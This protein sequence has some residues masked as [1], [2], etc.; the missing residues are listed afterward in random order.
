MARPSRSILMN[1]NENTD[2]E[3][4]AQTEPTLAQLTMHEIPCPKCDKT[5]KSIPAVRMHTIRA[6]G[7]GWDTSGNFGRGSKKR[8]TESDRLAY[9]REYQKKLRER[10]KLEGKNSRGYPLRKYRWTPEQTAKFRRTMRK[11][12]IQKAAKPQRFQIVYPDPRDKD[13]DLQKVAQQVTK[14]VMRFCPYCGESI[15]KHI[16]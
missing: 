14:A 8:R 16:R 12:A 9:K 13:I 1:T 5:F 15:E 4:L 2:T 6:H 3:P 7:E 11:K 10:Y